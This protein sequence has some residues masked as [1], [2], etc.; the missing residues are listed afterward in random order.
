MR[1]RVVTH[2]YDTLTIEGA[3]FAADWPA[4]IAEQDADGQAAADY[5]VPK[6]LTLRDEL[7]RYWR[8]AEALWAD[9]V[10]KAAAGGDP[11]KLFATTLLRDVF[12]FSDLVAV[13]ARM[14]RDRSYAISHEAGAGRVPVVIHHWGSGLDV[15]TKELGEG[16]RKRSAMGLVQEWLNASDGSLWGITTDGRTLRLVRDNASLT[17]PAFVQWDLARCFEERRYADFCTVWLMLHASRFGRTGDAPE[18]CALERWRSASKAAGVGARDRLRLGVEEALRALGNGA[19]RHPENSALRAALTNGRLD[20][21]GL[22]AELLRTVYRLIFVLVTEERSL[23]HPASS[24]AAGR[25]LYADGYAFRR[26]RDRALRRREKDRNDDVWR[27]MRVVLRGLDA[28]QPALA[29]PAFGGLFAAGQC[30]YLDVCQLDN[31]SI[32][33]AFLHLGWLRD[34]N[35]GTLERVNW[36]DMGPE[37]LG[38]VYESLLELV[39]QVAAGAAAFS[40]GSGAGNQRKLTGSYYT[41]DDLVQLLLDSALEPVVKPLL[42]YP[43]AEERLLSLAVLDPACGSGH[44]LLG[45]GRRLAGHLARLRAGGTPDPAQYGAALRDVT[46]RCLYGVDKN[47]MAIELARIALW[48]EAVT[49]DAPLAFVDHHLVHGDALLGVRELRVLEMGIP[50]TAF[51]DRSGDDK[52]VA[53]KLRRLNA[54]ARK[55]WERERKAGQITGRFNAE[56]WTAALLAVERM[57]DRTPADIQAKA[58]AYAE[59]V[60]NDVGSV[61]AACDAYLAAF[62]MPKTAETEKLV[63]TTG[64]LRNALLG[65]AMPVSMAEAVRRVAAAEPCLH[66]PLTFAPVMGRGGF[67]V[68]IGN[69]PWEKLKLQEQEYFAERAPVIATAR[70]AAAR[71]RA[72]AAL[73]TAPLGTPERALYHA[74]LRARGSAESPSA[75]VR[76]S[77]EDGGRCPLTGT[78]DVNLYAL[79]AETALTLVAPKGRAGLVLPSGIATD[80]GTAPFFAHI[81]DGRLVS[82]TDFENR[83]GLFPAVDSRMKFCLLVLGQSVEATFAFFLTRTSQLSDARRRFTLTAEEIKRLNPNTR[84]CPT[85]RSQA[86][87]ELTAKIYSR[88]PVL[89]DES[90]ADGN[91]WGISFGTLFHMSNDSH[92]FKTAP[93]AGLVPLYEAKMVHHYDHRFGSYETRMGERGFR[94]LPDVPE[95]RLRDPAYSVSP[96]YW[97]SKLEVADRIGARWTRSWLLG[98]KDVTS[99]TNSRTMVS[100]FIPRAGAGHKLPLLFSDRFDAHPEEA[101]VFNAILSSFTFDYFARQKVGGLSM[102]YFILKQLPVPVPESIPQEVSRQL[103]SRALEL[104]CVSNDIMPLY[105]DVSARNQNLDSRALPQRGRPFL[106]N[107]ERREVLLAEL[108]AIIAGLYG[109]SRSELSFILEPASVYGAEY[110]S[111]TFRV[112]RDEETRTYGEFRSRRLVLDAWDRL[113]KVD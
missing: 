1:A 27:Q 4:R 28:G 86:D 29:L 107:R 62:L 35:S 54:E 74:F 100:S 70:N 60:A 32:L 22:Q 110:P 68:V 7:S 76:V 92:L 102:G 112:L 33:S 2:D 71:Q 105:D 109:L 61:R 40:Y 75:Y 97:V 49:P 58:V 66:W 94:V 24:D 106:W 12:G 113:S 57:P 99:A 6:G 93:G 50:E 9:A 72:I 18:E 77:E 98:F 82:L 91:P 34:K 43:D 90:R 38:S 53:T 13:P 81:S 80:A 63:P 19:L 101:L 41:P 36:R 59:V 46:S 20:A 11:A 42:D 5:G 111:E 47:A 52:P 84:T 21:V 55:S 8:M 16:N 45:A 69:P 14:Q 103:A 39:P 85:F 78:G 67:D 65:A 87:A 104:V 17:R 64:T 83:E 31:A 89:W 88:V 73:E 51:K 15:A 3:L 56:G 37:E 30:P 23:L 48:L 25:V 26:L 79:F 44:F 10:A 108:D 96:F 95:E